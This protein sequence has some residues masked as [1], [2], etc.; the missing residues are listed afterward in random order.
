MLRFVPA[1]VITTSICTIATIAL[2]QRNQE[3]IP[4]RNG[5]YNSIQRIS[6]N[7]QEIQGVAGE[8]R[9]W[10]VVTEGLNC[11]NGPGV[12]HRVN[13]QF[14]QEDLFQAASFG[15]G[16]SDEVIVIQRDNAGK[17]WLRVELNG[18]QC[19]VRANSRYIEPNSLE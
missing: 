9:S 11:R 2:A 6:A 5:D 12:N 4:D 19:F 18:G 14:A 13:R 1:I 15:R 10:R 3:P 8:H 16:G 7:G 17:P